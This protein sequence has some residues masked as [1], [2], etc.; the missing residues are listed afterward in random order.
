MNCP[1]AVVPNNRLDLV[2]NR[3]YSAARYVPH[4]AAPYDLTGETRHWLLGVTQ[5]ETC[6]SV[7]RVILGAVPIGLFAA[8]HNGLRDIALIALYD[9]ALADLRDV[10]RIGLHGVAR[11]PPLDAERV[12]TH[13]EARKRLCFVA[14]DDWLQMVHLVYLPQ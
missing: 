3:L 14:V 12:D 2:R 6:G 13:V 8:V 1:L 11:N 7:R 10:V 9:V 4:T 5:S